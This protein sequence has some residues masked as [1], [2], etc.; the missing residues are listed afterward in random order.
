SVPDIFPPRMSCTS[1]STGLRPQERRQ[2]D[3]ERTPRTLVP[4]DAPVAVV[5]ELE[6]LC[7]G[8]AAGVA[9]VRL[10]VEV[11]HH[12][13]GRAGMRERFR[14]DPAGPADEV[15]ASR[16]RPAHADDVADVELLR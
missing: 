2:I 11:V 16:L 4:G 9:G 15:L 5:D 7:G 3:V 6:L 14:R 13:P 12:P 1:L 8:H 10:E